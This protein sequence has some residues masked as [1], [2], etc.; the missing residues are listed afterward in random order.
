MK[1]GCFCSKAFTLIELLAVVLIIG[2]LAVVALP[3]YKLAVMK[4][5]FATLMPVVDAIARA[6]E[7]YYL[8]YRKYTRN[9]KEL[10][11]KFPGGVT[12]SQN[13]Q[14]VPVYSYKD[15]HCKVDDNGQVVY[16]TGEKYGYYG[17]YFQHTDYPG[18]RIC[19]VQ[20]SREDAEL[21]KRV[22]V[23]LGGEP[24]DDIQSGWI[25]YFLP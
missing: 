15:F 20:L 9:V 6:E 14:G 21:R 23:S 25:Y 24:H 22:C 2:I 8:T 18:Q 4:T 1:K 5:R 11:V 13:A 12:L 19:Y 10:G 16:C 17:R 3:Q 7:L